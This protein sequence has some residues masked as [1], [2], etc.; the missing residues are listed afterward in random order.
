[1]RGTSGPCVWDCLALRSA[2]CLRLRGCCRDGLL[3][4]CLEK[5]AVVHYGAHCY[6]LF[7]VRALVD[8]TD[9]LCRDTTC[10]ENSAALGTSQRCFCSKDVLSTFCP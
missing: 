5:I 8:R 6:Q 9:P 3:N 10:W 4:D 2:T 1:M 7:A